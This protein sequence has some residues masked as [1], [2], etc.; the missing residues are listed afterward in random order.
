MAAASPD[1]L[2]SAIFDAALANGPEAGLVC[3]ALAPVAV[4]PS[5]PKSFVWSDSDRSVAV[6]GPGDLRFDFG[7]LSAGWIEFESD[8]IPSDAELSISEYKMTW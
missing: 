7:V 2:R 4:H 8:D 3:Y 1:P 6:K 5:Q